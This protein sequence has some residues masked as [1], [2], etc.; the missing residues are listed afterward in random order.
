MPLLTVTAA[1]LAE[2]L[3]ARRVGTEDYA[4]AI[5]VAG[6]R[7]LPVGRIMFVARASGRSA[8]FWT[9]TGPTALDAGI[10]LAGEAETLDDAKGDLRQAFDRLL[11]WASMA[12][13]G[14]LRWHVDDERNEPA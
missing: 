7:R 4:I 10:G 13:S 2:E 12:R 5:Q 1:D 6:G 8:W 11:Y 9:I 3:L 14:E